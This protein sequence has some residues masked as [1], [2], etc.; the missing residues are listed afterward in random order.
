[1]TKTQF[2]KK[3]N[4]LKRQNTEYINGRIEKALN[5][6]AVDLSSYEDDFRLPKT[7]MCAICYDLAYNWEPF[8]KALKK[9]VKNLRCFL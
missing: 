7:V 6:G 9:E 8:D 5:S 1:M 4:E 2:R 3:M